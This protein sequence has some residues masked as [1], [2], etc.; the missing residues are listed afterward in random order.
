MGDLPITPR[1]DLADAAHPAP[2]GDDDAFFAAFDDARARVLRS[3][4]RWYAIGALAL[5]ALSLFGTLSDYLQNTGHPGFD[6]LYDAS[7]AIPF[8]LV[9]A[10]LH[11]RCAA[12]PT[13]ARLV[14]TA[15]VLTLCV[16]LVGMVYESLPYAS[17]PIDPE[18]TAIKLRAIYSALILPVFFTLASILIPMTM[19]E[20]RRI[21]LP[22]LAAYLLVDLSLLDA[23]RG[24]SIWAFL[25]AAAGTAP[26]FFWSAWRYREFDA[27]FRA[28]RLRERFQSLSGDV[29][30]LSAELAQARRLHEALFPSPLPSGPVLMG[31]RY[32]PMREIGGDFLFLHREDAPDALGALTLVLVDVSGHG[33]PAALAVNRL[34]GELQRF[35][36]AHPAARGESGRP[37]HLLASLND[38]AGAALA[39]QGMFA[40][41]FVARLDPRAN[42]LEYASAGH[43]TAFLRRTDAVEP[44]TSTTTMLGVVPREEFDPDPRDLNFAIADRLLAYTDGAMEARD[45]SGREFSA[46]RIRSL[47]AQAS[48]P[49][50]PGLGRLAPLADL[51]MSEVAAF[52]FGKPSDDTLIVELRLGDRHASDLTKSRRGGDALTRSGPR[53]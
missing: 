2:A 31:F 37:G 36:A 52:R 18:P 14:D 43:P 39:P 12:S 7:L 3:R 26:G 27:R 19:R 32:E 44:L 23:P 11:F 5:V 1:A 46:D 41:A 24:L 30:E 9:L 34:H 50:R 48:L 40:T 51:V 8:I 47:I 53:H 15:T 35:F 29:K 28:D 38:Y 45:R 22:G 20:L 49:D 21:V 42:A 10:W 4:L 6:V 25:L 17:D 33:I 16:S 13:R